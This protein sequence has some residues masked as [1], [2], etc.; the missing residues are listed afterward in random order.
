MIIQSDNMQLAAKRNYRESRTYSVSSQVLDNKPSQN[1]FHFPNINEDTNHNTPS[2]ESANSLS[3]MVNRYQTTYNV[4]ASRIQEQLRA[5]DQIKRQTIDY[6]MQLLFGKTQATEPSNGV[7][8][9]TGANFSTQ[10]V[11]QY[12]YFTYSEIETTSFDA[13]GTVKTADG[14]E[15]NFNF[16]LTMSRSFTQTASSYIDF[17]QPVLCD[18]LVI[19]LNSNIAAVSDQKFFFDLDADGKEEE[20]SSLNAGSGYLALDHNNDGVINDGSELFGTT[21]GNGFLDLAQYDSDN[22]GWIDETDAIF[23]HL[24]IWTMEPNGNHKLCTLSDSGVGALYLGSSDTDFS[25]KDAEN[26]TNGMIRKT[27]LFL[28]ENGTSGTLQQLDLAT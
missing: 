12:A 4:H 9:D 18:P 1:I 3:E 17:T 6:L 27:G 23:K 7:Y 15:I 20:I 24:K 2:H 26:N 11:R 5:L 8:Y 25:L 16:N 14:R 13:S 28:Y 10:T 21:S 19:N 22:N